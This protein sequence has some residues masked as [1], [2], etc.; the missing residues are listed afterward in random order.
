MAY[1]KENY[2]IIK[3]EYAAK[4]KEAKD[5]A[6]ERARELRSRFPEI[7]EIDAAIAK[8]SQQL[9]D[10][11]MRGSDYFDKAFPAIREETDELRRV[12]G[13]CLVYHGYPADYS[14]VKYECEKCSDTGVLDGYMCDC[15][16]EKLAMLGYR[17]AGI[18]KLAAKQSFENFSLDFYKR[19]EDRKNAELAFSGS[20]SFAEKFSNNGENLL[21]IGA[22]G[23]GKTHLA[24]AAAKAVIDG[25]YDVV[26]ESAF[27]IFSD[28]ERARF[29]RE[30]EED[31][32]AKYMNCDL[33]VIDDLGAEV[34]GQFQVACLYNIV[35]TRINSGSS[36]LITTNL[37]PAELKKRYTDRIVSRLF[38]EFAPYTLTGSDIRAMKLR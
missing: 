28:F 33:L 31:P 8:T 12:R 38:G 17:S 23:L 6:E 36:M 22:T 16:K 32:C 35:N 24:V 30:G 34:S 18:E 3:R 20:R 25:G 2:R 4:N 14:D 21:L 10:A 26:F 5:A 37:S 11:A 13:E 15:M 29:R 7:A 19:D 27:N 9:L 1:N